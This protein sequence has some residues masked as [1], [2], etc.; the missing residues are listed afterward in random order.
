[1][2]YKSG[3]LIKHLLIDLT[4][5]HLLTAEYTSDIMSS[6][7][8][9]YGNINNGGSQSVT[10]GG[11]NHTNGTGYQ[12]V[13]HTSSSQVSSG[14]KFSG[15]INNGHWQMNT[16]EH[17]SSG[18]VKIGEFQVNGPYI[19]PPSGFEFLEKLSKA[20]TAGASD[21]S[22]TCIL[23]L[24]NCHQLKS[25]RH[26]CTSRCRFREPRRNTPGSAHPST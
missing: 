4:L 14:N 7:T 8:G 15:N 6:Q 13:G 18:N 3:K 2:G 21:V 5:S 10:P 1:M 16:S 24:L 9:Q 19:A 26:S 25:C 12:H 23:K 17:N 11:R 22:G 20:D